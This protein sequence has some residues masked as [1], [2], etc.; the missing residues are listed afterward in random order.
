MGSWFSSLFGSSSKV[1]ITNVTVFQQSTKSGSY[2]Y[3]VK[4]TYEDKR[5]KRS[6]KDNITAIFTFSQFDKL[7]TDIT[8]YLEHDN[9][10]TKAPIPKFNECQNNV[11]ETRLT[12]P[13]SRS[14][15]R[16]PHC[17]ERFIKSLQN[18][19][20]TDTLDEV[21][22]MIIT[23]GKR[24]KKTSQAGGKRL[25]KSRRCQAKT[26]KNKRCRSHTTKGT[27]CHRHCK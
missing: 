18:I 9:N 15:L 5:Y 4:F 20:D 19:K 14:Q 22:V 13:M 1:K 2:K 8:D 3:I 12:G 21:N 11:L 7:V 23:W 27:H 25:R 17:F 26:A 16:S 10:K 6:D 24:H